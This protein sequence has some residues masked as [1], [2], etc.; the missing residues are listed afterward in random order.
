MLH[1]QLYTG[2]SLS[3]VSPPFI[4][5]PPWEKVV[6]LPKKVVPP[7]TA[8]QKYLDALPK[9][10]TFIFSFLL[11]F[12][13]TDLAWGHTRSVA[14]QLIGNNNQ[15]SYIGRYRVAL[16]FS[17]HPFNTAPTILLFIHLLLYGALGN[18]TSIEDQNT[19]WHS[20]LLG[21]HIMSAYATPIICII[22][23]H[24]LKDLTI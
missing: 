24:I 22:C 3:F 2:N 18:M 21:M 8:H 12:R 14:M 4:F 15:S 10:A 16:D 1:P 17:S 13:A 5:H 20:I 7:C 11:I 9:W 23:P 6:L 19:E